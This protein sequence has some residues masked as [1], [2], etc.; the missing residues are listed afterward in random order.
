MM[1][2]SAAEAFSVNARVKLR[3][4]V[5]LSMARLGIGEGNE[6]E[7]VD[8]YG[9]AVVL[10]LPGGLRVEI[11]SIEAGWRKKL[12]EAVAAEGYDNVV[13]RVAYTWFNRLIAIRYMEVNDYLP[14][15]VRVLS[16]IEAGKDEPD[17][18]T[19]CIRMADVFRLSEDE[20]NEIIDLRE[21][22][23]TDE[24]FSKMFLYECRSLNAILPELF[25]ETKQYE[26]L[27]I[28]LSYTVPD[29]VVRDLVD[30]VPEEDFRD[31]VQIIGWMYQYYNSEL[32]DK[33]FS[34]LKKNIKISKERI[35]AATQL[36]TPDWIV[37]YMVE[38]SLGRVWLEGHPDGNLQSKWKYYLEEAE[39]EPQV[40]EKLKELRVSRRN[41]EPTDI[42]V[43]DPCMGSGHVL[44]YA[45][46]VLVQ[47][48]ESYG[49][50]KQDAASLIVR[51]NIFGLDIDERAYQLAYFAIMMKARSY[52]SNIFNKNPKPNLHTM[53]ETSDLDDSCLDGYGNGMLPAEKNLAYND[54]KYILSSF[55]DAKTY[56]SLIKIH[57]LDYGRIDTFIGSR[58]S[59]LYAKDDRVKE[60]VAVAKVL[61]KKYDAVIT[62]P[63]YMGSSGMSAKLSKYV[64]DE[65]PDVKSDLFACFIERGLDL[66]NK[67]GYNSMVTMQS[68]MFLSSFEKFRHTILKNKT[69]SQLMHM[70][71]MVMGIAFGTA[72]SIIQNAMLSDYV[73]IYHHVALNNVSNGNVNPFPVRD[74]R[75]SQ[76][77]QSRFDAIPG[78]PIAYW[79]SDKLLSAFITGVPLETIASL[80]V[81][82]QTGENARF[83]RFWYEVSLKKIKF[84]CKSIEESVLSGCKWFPYN[85]GGEYRKWYG[86]NESVVNW[87]NDGFEIRHF[88]DEKGKLKSVLRNTK[89]YFQPAVTWSKISSGS[90][91]FRFKPHGHIFDVAG[92]SIFADENIR[93]YIHGFCNSK[94]ALTIANAI[95]PTLNY[96]VGHIASFPIILSEIFVE[97]INKIV[98]LNIE[99]SRSEWD[100][101]EISWDF[102]RNPLVESNENGLIKVAF[103][104]YNNNNHEAFISLKKNEERLNEI[105]IEIYGLK[106]EINPFVDDKSVT[107]RNPSCNHAVVNLISYAV[108]CMFGRYSLDKEGLINAGG[109]WV[110][111]GPSFKAD[112]DNIIPINDN[113]Y[114]GD[115]IVVRF[116]EFIKA[117]FGEENLE[118]NL[119]YIADNLG[120]KYVGTARDGIRKYFLNNFYDDH[121]KM[122]QKRPIYWLFDSGKENGF[123]ALIYMHRYTP[124][125]IPTMRQ[126]YLLPMLTRY[127]EM[128]KSLEGTEKINLQK[129]IEEIQ[130]YDIAME[131]YASEKISIDL[132]DGVKVNYAKFQNIENPGSK[133]KID[134]LHP[135]K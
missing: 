42:K 45:F 97:E 75:F 2:K 47:I 73:G 68:W 102:K 131:K 61:S 53:V 110:D 88:V 20:K 40:K 35:P 94:V 114:F 127:V 107:I 1:D 65:Y 10:N 25:T 122:F 104:K 17:I 54:M 89:Y 55:R 121:V 116:V 23:K 60:A 70:D 46:D 112:P 11:T 77:K 86:N 67:N 21:R 59:S 32:K 115:D 49:Y 62:N 16:S 36:F 14:T 113:E 27:L 91:A 5:E 119:K 124:D 4:S 34:D 56:G 18:V 44:V 108:G 98:K 69:I 74:N 9:T 66:T 26:K 28:N 48:Y 111:P 64:K 8:S 80:R 85:K 120:I 22:N 19:Q 39:Q 84:D 103:D 93:N 13:E 3:K 38:N 109:D 101:Y 135:L 29:G 78:A 82:L 41:T 50:S 117:A 76:I 31:A 72:V 52:D 126:D 63:P 81:G 130:I 129:K 15:H 133:K 30:T 83:V 12:I 128:S 57:G 43:I 58:S 125:L 134:L 71:N 79:V 6:P 37:R 123:K 92:T 7:S 99:L 87:E 132:D 105:F 95:S 90:I 24:L 51:N 118:E 96:E 100:S 106:C 33:V